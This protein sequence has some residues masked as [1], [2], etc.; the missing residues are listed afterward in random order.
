MCPVYGLRGLVYIGRSSAR[1]SFAL[2]LSEGDPQLRGQILWIPPLNWT[3]TNLPNL[4]FKKRGLVEKSLSHM[5]NL[6]PDL[7]IKERKCQLGSLRNWQ[8]CVGARLKFWQRSRVPHCS[9]RLRRQISLD[10]ITTALPPNLTRL[11]HNTASYAGY[12]WVP[13]VQPH[14]TF[15]ARP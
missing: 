13:S 1:P 5:N 8:Y 2:V 6:A 7:V 12:N 14:Q 11:L 10:Y 15:S 3:N 9:W 4:H